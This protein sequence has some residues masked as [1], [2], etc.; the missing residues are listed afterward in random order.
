MKS[1]TLTLADPNGRTF[2]IRTYPDPGIIVRNAVRLFGD[3]LRTRFGVARTASRKAG[4]QIVIERPEADGGDDQ[5]FDIRSRQTGAGWQLVLSGTGERAILYG[6]CEILDQ[7]YRGKGTVLIPVLN[8]RSSPDIKKRG[9]ERHS[10]PPF[11][12]PEGV[13]KNIELIRALA[14]K[15]VNQLLWLDGWINPAWYRF[16]DFRHYPKL[17]PYVSVRKVRQAKECLRRVVQE[18]R[19]WGMDFYLGT[20]E[21]NVPDWLLEASPDMFRYSKAGFPIVRFDYAETWTFYRAKIREMMEDIP[22]LAGIELWTAEAMDPALCHVARP[23]DWSLTRRI[24]HMYTQALQAMDEAGRPD[25]R[26]VCSTFIHHPEGEGAYKPLYGKLP[27]RCDGRMKSQVEDFYRFNSPTTLA[28]RISPGREWIEFDLNG[29]LRGGWAGWIVVHLNYFHE[30]MRHYYGRGVRQFIHRSHVGIAVEELRGI[31]SIKYDAFFAW[32]WNMRLSVNEI[33]RRCK[34]EGYPDEMLEFYL[35]SEKLSDRTMY[36]GQCLMNNLHSGFHGSVEA[37]E[38]EYPALDVYGNV[39]P[40]KRRWILEPTEQNLRL[41]IREKEDA[42]KCAER[43]QAI[44]K[45]CQKRLPGDAYEKLQRT[46]DYQQAAVRV[47]RYHTE[48]YFR[49]RLYIANRGG[50]GD[51][52]KAA[53]QCEAEIKALRP[54][55]EKRADN[56]FALVGNIRSLAFVKACTKQMTPKGIIRPDRLADYLK[57]IQIGPRRH[58]RSPAKRA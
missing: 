13:A 50:Y 36:V 9:N 7:A 10:P 15:R 4:S 57:P 21:L 51:V 2:T 49:Y 26:V 22:G 38:R 31:Q 30:R 33:W 54:L 42:V 32:C 39:A 18:A 1:Q 12:T 20:T 23:Q 14:R 48:M 58:K 43:M 52:M 29:E 46:M 5:T 24:L 8:M 25:G 34:P 17:A 11:D 37:Y 53:D 19:D 40:R 27:E 28:G 47:W 45:S 55:N 16:L 41:I 3:E 35:L 6:I 44:L 56:A